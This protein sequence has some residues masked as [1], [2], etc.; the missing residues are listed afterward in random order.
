MMDEELSTYRSLTGA[1]TYRE[2]PLD[3]QTLVDTKQCEE[4]ESMSACKRELNP[5]ATHC[6]KDRHRVRLASGVG[7]P[8]RTLEGKR[9]STKSN[10]TSRST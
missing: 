5:T 1:I 7:K 6:T 2:Y 4:L 9:K 10:D 8:E 3:L